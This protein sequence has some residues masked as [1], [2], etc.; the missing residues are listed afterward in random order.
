MSV[1]IGHACQDEN[2]KARG[3]MPG[4]QTGRE[5][6]I[7]DWYDRGGGWGAYIECKDDALGNKFASFMEQICK[8]DS[9]GYDQDDRKTGYQ[10]IIA[11]G[12]IEAA[13]NSEFD[14]SSLVYACI[15]LSGINVPL[16]STHSMEKTLLATGMFVAYHDAAHLKTCDY[17][18]RGGIY[19]KAGK[20]VAMALNDG[21]KAGQSASPSSVSTGSSES[22]SSKKT[23]PRIKEAPNVEFPYILV[24]KNVRLR[25]G[26]SKKSSS[27]GYLAKG[28]KVTYGDTDPDNGWHAVDTSAGLGFVSG[29]PIYTKLVTA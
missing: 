26:P 16:G 9:F 13:E 29:D 11:A 2:G 14:C 17:A 3:G 22:N 4:D 1:K 24:V 12:S 21:P 23:I 7:Q 28:T 10:A 20:H 27:I 5:T 18:K 15:L 6:R 8:D 19:L 25:T